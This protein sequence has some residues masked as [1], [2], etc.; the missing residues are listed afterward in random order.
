[1]KN[2]KKKIELPVEISHMNIMIRKSKKLN[3]KRKWQ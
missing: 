2:G 3:N 1:M